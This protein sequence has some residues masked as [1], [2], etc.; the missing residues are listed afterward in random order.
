MSCA[1]ISSSRST[2]F[3]VFWVQPR[4]HK[5][6]QSLL[7]LLFCLHVNS[8]ATVTGNRAHETGFKPKEEM[9]GGFTLWPLNNFFWYLGLELTQESESCNSKSFY[10]S[11]LW[12]GSASKNLF[13]L[14]LLCCSPTT[15]LHVNSN[16]EIIN[17]LILLAGVS[18]QWRHLG[19]W[20]SSPWACL[21]FHFMGPSREGISSANAVQEHCLKLLW[22]E[23]QDAHS[24]N[25]NFSVCYL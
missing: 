10:S 8:T 11:S 3:T 21:R 2:L 16:G 24:P 1:D 5:L 6:L 25:H 13:A 19:Y 12:A 17:L 14:E 9:W 20:F 7:H 4:Y 15:Y 18:N 23:N 22:K